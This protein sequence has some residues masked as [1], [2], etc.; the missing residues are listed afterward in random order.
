MNNGLLVDSDDDIQIQDHSDESEEALLQ[1]NQQIKNLDIHNLVDCEAQTPPIAFQI[2]ATKSTTSS[3]CAPVL[4]CAYSLQAL[5]SHY[6]A[7]YEFFP[8]NLRTIE[9]SSFNPAFRR[10]L[11]HMPPAYLGPWNIECF[12]KELAAVIFIYA[13]KNI[14]LEHV[15]GLESLFDNTYL[16]RLRGVLHRNGS[17]INKPAVLISNLSTFVFGLGTGFA[18][19]PKSL[20]EQ[21]RGL[22]AFLWTGLWLILVNI[23]NYFRERSKTQA[24]NRFLHEPNALYDINDVAPSHKAEEL[25]SLLAQQNHAVQINSIRTHLQAYHNSFPLIDSHNISLDEIPDCCIDVVIKQVI[26]KCQSPDTKTA[27]INGI[28]AHSS[29]RP[30]LYW[31]YASRSQPEAFYVGNLMPFDER[32]ENRITALTESLRRPTTG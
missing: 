9:F 16:D 4:T 6:Q 8:P 13:L 32:S 26:D 27:L 24:V 21:S 22:I 10:N 29:C 3:F 14:S 23:L 11:T 12:R 20:A 2:K 30:G 15:S 18:I 1:L 17:F 25:T 28:Q 19:A 31:S 7:L 5:D